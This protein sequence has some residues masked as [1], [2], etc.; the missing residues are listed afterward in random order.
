MEISLG[1]MTCEML[2]IIKRDLLEHQIDTTRALMRLTS[3]ETPLFVE[4]VIWIK[5][6]GLI[7]C[8]FYCMALSKDKP[9]AAHDKTPVIRTRFDAMI[10]S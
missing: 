9:L 4:D 8:L 2:V 10:S 3:P 7:K 1:D 6:K 5:N